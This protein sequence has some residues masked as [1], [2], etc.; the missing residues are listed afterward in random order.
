LVL[1]G[2]S[3]GFAE[4][5]KEAPKIDPEADR[6]LKEMSVHLAGLGSLAA[7]A[8]D[9]V[10]FVLDSGQ[11]IQLSHRRRSKIRR[12]NKVAA[13]VDGDDAHRRMWYN[14]E[15]LTFLDA[16]HNVYAVADA[17]DT[18]GETIEFVEKTLEIHVPLGDLLASDPYQVLTGRV[19]SGVYLGRHRVGSRKCHHL[20]FT[21]EHVDWQIW[22]DAEGSPLPRKVLIT[23]KKQPSHP[24]YTVVI[25]KFEE[26]P[27]LPDEEFEFTPPEGATEVEFL[28]RTEVSQPAEG[29]GEE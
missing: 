29:G 16:D 3:A 10:D 21:Q 13:E 20:A 22:I 19:N 1:L 9:A 11:K 4:E 28:T 8:E 17:P 2:P 27:E 7:E 15:T 25:S 24:Q 18:I 26:N 23:Y 5:G 6:V 14:G 12:P